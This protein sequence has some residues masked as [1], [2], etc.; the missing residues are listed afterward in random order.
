[1]PPPQ[2]WEALEL[3][4]WLPVTTVLVRVREAEVDEELKRIPAP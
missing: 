1:M 4:A 3:V 2:I